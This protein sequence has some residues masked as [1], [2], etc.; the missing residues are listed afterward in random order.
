MDLLDLIRAAE[1][2]GL[3]RRRLDVLRRRVLGG[4][5]DRYRSVRLARALR[6]WTNRRAATA[7]RVAA[8][9]RP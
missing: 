5:V 3:S 2:L 7:I 8:S 6:A 4:D 9:D 1:R